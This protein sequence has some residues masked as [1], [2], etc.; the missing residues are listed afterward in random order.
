MTADLDGSQPAPPPPPGCGDVVGA[1]CKVSRLRPYPRACA[2]CDAAASSGRRRGRVGEALLAYA[3]GE[4]H[5][6]IPARLGRPAATVR[7]WLRRFAARVEQTRQH[8]TR[9]LI[10]LDV[11]VVRIEPPRDATPVQTALFVL[12][13]AAAAADRRLGPAGSRWEVASALCSGR[14]LANTNCPYPAPW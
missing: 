7:G 12:A 13:A 8:A 14:L 11:G 5:R 3:A 4:G 2:R 10:R 1:A 6:P 9:W